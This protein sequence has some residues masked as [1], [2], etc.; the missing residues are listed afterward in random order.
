MLESLINR[1][2]VWMRSNVH[3]YYWSRKIYF[4]VC[5]L[6]K[7]FHEQEFKI[8]KKNP[9]KQGGVILDVG[10]NDGI[11]A[12]SARCYNKTNPI[13]SLEPNLFH[14]K[15]LRWLSRWAYNFSYL[16]VGGGGI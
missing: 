11:S 3:L 10:A 15:R 2:E 12:L 4:W 6:L 5:F 8:L 7:I 13:L 16:I 14:E 9:E 1:L